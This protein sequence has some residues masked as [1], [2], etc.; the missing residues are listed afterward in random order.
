MCADFC[1]TAAFHF[2]RSYFILGV[3]Y[4]PNGCWIKVYR[5]RRIRAGGGARLN[6]LN[7]YNGMVQILRASMVRV[8]S[9]WN[10]LSIPNLKSIPESSGHRPAYKLYDI[11]LKR[12]HKNCCHLHALRLLSFGLSESRRDS[13]ELPT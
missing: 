12:S 6:L 5:P 8:Y 10:I 2:H 13:F 3:V 4:R 9:D 11:R 7:C 1:R